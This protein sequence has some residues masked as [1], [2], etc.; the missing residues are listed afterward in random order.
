M[1]TNELSYNVTEFYVENGITYKMNV[2]ISLNDYC[3]MVYVIGVSRL[4]Y[5]RN[6]GT[7]VLFGALVVATMRKY[8]SVF[9]SLKRLL[10]YICATITGNLCIPLK[11]AFTTLKTATKKLP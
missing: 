7:G 9:Q 4:I 10:T 6:V 1:K 5:M 2:R 8:S 11:M 3:K